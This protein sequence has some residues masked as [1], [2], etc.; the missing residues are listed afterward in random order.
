MSLGSSP[1]N[2]RNWLSR[3]P[4]PDCVKAEFEGGEDKTVRIGVNRSKFRD[5][6][7]A[8]KGA[9]WLQALD[10]QG[11]VLREWSDEGY[12]EAAEKTEAVEAV[13]G[14]SNALLAEYAKLLSNAYENGAKAHAEAYKMAFELMALLCNTI[15]G[16]N[17]ALEKVLLESIQNAPEQA[18][19]DPNAGLVAAILPA[20]AASLTGGVAPKPPAP[21]NGAP[22]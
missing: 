11:V 4:H 2:L 13:G 1:F 14:T 15:I 17:A 19:D 10:P 16:R 12:V 5:A 7:M 3:R 20:L 21:S 8:L 9:V 18:A 22:Q 6:E